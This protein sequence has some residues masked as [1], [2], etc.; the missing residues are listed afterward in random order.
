[1]KYPL[2]RLVM[3][4]VL[5]ATCGLFAFAQSS[6]SASL[7]G[8]VLDQNGA[9]ISGASIVVK[10]NTTGTEFRVASSGNG[11]FTVPAL[12]AGIYTVTIEAQGFKKGVVQNVEIQAATPASVN[13]S[14]EVGAA[15]ESVVVQGGGEV[16]QT[17]TATSQQPS[18]DGRSMNCRLS[19]ATPC[20][21][22]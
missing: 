15:S 1:M 11:T 17:Q 13:I 7:S 19:R 18:P 12:N 14:L 20:S 16:L 10:S 6:T 8:T 3:T 22:C 5:A 4:V 2:L 21:L 9:A